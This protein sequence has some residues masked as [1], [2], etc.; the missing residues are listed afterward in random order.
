MVV[1]MRWMVVVCLIG[2][3]SLF[4][5]NAVAS[6]CAEL[7]PQVWQMD[8]DADDVGK[9]PEALL[10]K[11][12]F[13]QAGKLRNLDE[14]LSV[15]TAPDGTPAIEMRVVEGENRINSFHSKALAD[16]N[17]TKACISAEVFFETG[18]D[19]ARAGTKIGIGL[20]GGDG[21]SG[22][23]DSGGWPPELQNGWS[24]RILNNRRGMRVYAYHLEREGKRRSQKRCEPHG[25][26]W[27]DTIP[28][29]A[30]LRKGQWIPLDLE[31]VVNDVGERNG[32]I[33]FWVDGVLASQKDGLVFRRDEGWHIRGMKFTDMWGGNTSAPK[34]FS[35]KPQSHWYAKYRIF[36]AS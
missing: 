26:L 24:V 10:R 21:S 23:K 20:W 36:G 6:V 9:P 7:Y 18:F 31:V 25:C 5:L 2:G 22:R 12:G 17:L 11:P 15:G 4:G 35:P 34:N 33:R 30:K 13:V 29:V 28:P 1:F 3:S 14:R 19:H 8:I 32:S 16:R 27:G